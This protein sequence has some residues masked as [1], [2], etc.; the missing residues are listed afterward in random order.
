MTKIKMP[1]PSK[2]IS[3]SHARRFLLAHQ[4]LWPPRKLKGKDGIMAFVRHVGCI[5]FDPI[6]IVGRNPDLVLQ[7]RVFGYRPDMLEQ[8]LYKDRQLVDGWDKAASIYPTTDW[9][10]FARHRALMREQHGDPTKP[11]MKIAPDVLDAIRQ[12]GPLSSIDFRR[13]D[14]V[15]WSWGQP[16]RLTRA[17]LETLYAM[18]VLLVQHRVGSRRIFDLAENLLPPEILAAPEPNCTTEAFQDW[19]VLR[20]VG[21]LGLASPGASGY[22]WPMLGVKGET[23]RGVLRRLVEQGELTVV[24]IEGLPKNSFI[25]RTL[26]LPT[27]EKV[28]RGRR[29]KVQAAWIG[30]LDNLTWDRGLLLRLF[31]FEYA[32]EVYKPVAKRKFGY[33]VLP[34]LHGDRFI[35]RVEPIFDRENRTLILQ[36]WW[37]EEDVQVNDPMTK[38]LATCLSAFMQYLGA[39]KV[40][41]GEKMG[42]QKDMRWAWNPNLV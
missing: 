6:N 39:E 22:W 10:Y 26:D 5:Q 2:T 17:S 8:L 19:Q 25:L 18:G 7:S 28:Q 30:P 12:R 11:A 9:P 32:W 33:Y 31:N 41:L 24:G 16:T 40:Q 3:V 29:P 38:A 23:R 37:W 27:L 14:M 20:R 36:N 21:G 4:R 1:P 35:A 34:V 42:E 15:D 13:K